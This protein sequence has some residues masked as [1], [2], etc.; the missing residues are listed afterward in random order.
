MSKGL[1]AQDVSK[2]PKLKTQLATAT[3]DS[4]RVDALSLL[5]FSYSI[6]HTDTALMYGNSAM[7]LAEKIKYAKGIADSY[8][9]LG[10]TYFHKGDYVKAEEHL[11]SSL[12][13]F[14]TIGNK[15][16]I[17]KTILKFTATYWYYF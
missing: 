7:K 15:T 8:N 12:E 11:Q 16:F 13:K 4:D 6:V 10:W 1:L 14:R 2:I 9:T 5:C 17:K 3:A